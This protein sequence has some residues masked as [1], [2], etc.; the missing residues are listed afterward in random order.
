M[1][2]DL[3]CIFKL[4]IYHDW[5]LI[6]SRRLLGYRDVSDDRLLEFLLLANFVGG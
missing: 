4:K 6:P 1:I 2:F 3:R 5:I